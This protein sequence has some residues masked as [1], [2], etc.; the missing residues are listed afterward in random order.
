M[1]KFHCV[2]DD[3]YQKLLQKASDAN[4]E[5]SENTN[6]ILDTSTS[7]AN[8]VPIASVEEE[9]KQPENVAAGNALLPATDHCVYTGSK[10]VALKFVPAKP[11]VSSMASPPEDSPPASPLSEDSSV[12]DVMEQNQGSKDTIIERWTYF[13]E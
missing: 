13:S 1:I 7:P 9:K 5:S 10:P 8:S 11:L 12:G 3:K 4:S 6:S 2:A